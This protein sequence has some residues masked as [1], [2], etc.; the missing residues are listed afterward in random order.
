VESERGH[1]IVATVASI[2]GTCNAG[3]KAGDTIDVS[4]RCTGGMCGYLYHAA[5]PYIL[6]LQFGGSFPWDDANE[7][8]L[9][10]PDGRN[11]L[12]LRVRRAG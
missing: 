6:M 9:T 1:R 11:L 10:C 7:V 5:F 12:T 4:A 8:E 2:K 3:H